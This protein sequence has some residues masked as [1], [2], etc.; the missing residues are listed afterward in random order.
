MLRFRVRP[1]IVLQPEYGIPI[2]ELWKNLEMCSEVDPQE[3]GWAYKVGVA[4]S[5]ATLS[6]HNSNF[7]SEVLTK[8]SS[9]RREYPLST[10]EQKLVQGK[11]IV[12]LPTGP[13]VV[14]IPADDE[15]PL[16]KDV[17][18]PVAEEQR[19]SIRIQS[20]LVEIGVQLGL[21]ATNF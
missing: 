3:V 12:D 20:K 15:E 10:Y 17:L 8:Q 18:L 11:R 5:L 13:A 7:L 9:D 16:G 4:R 2:Q 19:R 1:H 14:E 6:A 21:P